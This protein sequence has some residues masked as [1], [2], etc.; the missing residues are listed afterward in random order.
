[1]YNGWHCST[2]IGR[3]TMAFDFAGFF[4]YAHLALFKRECAFYRLTPKRFA[5]LAG[6]C[7]LYP[8][9]ETLIWS[10]FLLDD[11]WFREYRRQ[12]IRR[13]VLI[14]GNPRSGTTFLYRVLAQ[15]TP[16]FT[17]THAWESL[18]APSIA[19]RK[20]VWGLAV[21][22]RRFGSPLKRLTAAWEER[23]RRAIAMHSFS[24]RAPEEDEHF[25]LHVW[26]TVEIWLFTAILEGAIPLTY[27]ATL[28]EPD[29]QRIM[30]YYMRCV[31]CH[32]YAHRADPHPGR[33]YLAKNPFASA[34]IGS[35]YEHLPGVR[36][37]YLAR[38]P[39]DMI[40]SWISS[41]AYGW[42]LAGGTPDPY[43]SRDY[44]LDMAEHW[45]R[46]PLECFERAPRDSYILVKFDDLIS[47]VEGTVRDIYRRFG[48]DWNASVAQAVR[49]AAERSRRYRSSHVYSLE[50]VGLTRE[51][52]VGRFADIMDRF[53]FDTRGP[54]TSPAV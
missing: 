54:V 19:L 37:I 22:D 34:K 42:R 13:P 33:H 39:L 25:Y 38:N 16:N 6:L 29:R 3:Q 2:E 23:G 48:L 36:F 12:D 18:L 20:L 47:D 53:G 5:R 7:A 35:L 44:V 17:C 46:Y 4:R 14:V 15:D 30:S 21:L 9:F 28:L 43:A 26:S 40:P 11:I 32:L 24:L 50:Q 41:V 45:Y 8:L 27:F 10:G 49:G 1:M 52:I 31:Q 51:Q